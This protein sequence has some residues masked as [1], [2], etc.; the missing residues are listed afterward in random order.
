MASPCGAIPSVRIFGDEKL[1]I[2]EI[3]SILN[4]H[5]DQLTGLITPLLRIGEREQKAISALHIASETTV[6]WET[7]EKALRALLPLHAP[8]TNAISVPGSMNFT[9]RSSAVE[10]SAY[11]SAAMVLAHLVRDWATVGLKTRKRVHGPVL[12]ELRRLRQEKQRP[13][14]VLVPGAGTS[15]LAWDI[16]R[17]GNRVEANDVSAAMLIAAHTLMKGFEQTGVSQRHYEVYPHLQCAHGIVRRAACLTAHAIPEK[18]TMCKLQPHHSVKAIG[19]QGWL[20]LQVGSWLEPDNPP[21]EFGALRHENGTFD[22]VVTSY[23]LDTQRDPIK[24]ILRVRSMLQPGGLWINVCALRVLI[25][26]MR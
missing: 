20:T 19:L 7:N 11:S 6:A 1:A 13:L 25:D 8:F 21:A 9:S 2:R 10:S 4:Q 5:S 26:Q 17:H 14:S 22:S 16:A 12:R 3:S 23:F 15:R 18:E 24:T